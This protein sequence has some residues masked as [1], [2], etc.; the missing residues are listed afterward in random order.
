MKRKSL[1]IGA[2]ALLVLML[3]GLGAVSLLRQAS[4]KRPAAG[5]PAPD[6]SIG[7]YENYRAGQPATVQLSQMKGKVVILN[8]W[9]SWCIPCKDEAPALQAIQ[10]KYATQDVVLLGI[11][12]LDTEREA[13]GFLSTYGIAYANGIDLKQQIAHQYRIT[14]VPETFIVDKQGIVREVFIQ[15]ITER[16]LSNVL[17]R[18]LA[19]P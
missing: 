1:L 14:G 15:P 6:F 17:D 3:I 18:L 12:Y 9:A 11:N 16:Q 10:D 4:D 2:V 5:N 13:L 8:F 7:L 19:E